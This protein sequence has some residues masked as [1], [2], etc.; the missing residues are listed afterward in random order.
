MAVGW[1]EGVVSMCLAEHTG[2]SVY[3]D[4]VLPL[5]PRSAL[6]LSCMWST[7]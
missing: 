6:L 5:A 4:K 1:T 3:L 2:V 7:E